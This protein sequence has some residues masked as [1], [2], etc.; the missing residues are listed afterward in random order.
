MKKVL[1]ITY[2][3]PPAGGPGVQR[4]LKFAK[5]L[6]E[7]GWQPIILTV[8]NGEY[9]A[10]DN[11]LK[12]EIPDSCIVYRTKSLEPGLIYKKF[13]G[14]K[15]NYKIPV[16]VLTEKNL[17]WK[18]RLAN[19]IRLNLII[20]D[21]KI[22]WKSFA[23]KEGKKIINKHK[24]DII[25]SSSPPPTVHLIARK[26]A[27]W[28]KLRWISDFRDPWTKIH[29][30]RGFTKNYFAQRLD[31]A[32]EKSVLDYASKI[33]AVNRGFFDYVDQKKFIQL[34][35]GFDSNELT[36][37]KKNNANLKFTIVYSGALKTRQ[38]V[39]TFFDILKNL[40]LR[41]QFEIIGNVDP[42]VRLMMEEKQ[43]PHDVVYHGF[44]SHNKVIEAIYNSDLLLLIIGKSDISHQ[45]YSTKLFEYLMVKKPILAYG[46]INGAADNLIK[47]TSAGKLFDYDDIDGP[48]KFISE[49]YQ[50]WE[51]NISYSG[52]KKKEIEKYE[53][54]E[55]TNKLVKIFEEL[56]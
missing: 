56:L 19:W 24:P 3:W 33:C 41:I 51:K 12:R 52:F 48:K 2:Y 44:Q 50:S 29:Y 26:L 9:P 8:E 53:R 42:Q 28:S 17:S 34:T 10:S 36:V 32:L 16:A 23:V 55:L 40:S 43:L 45:I 11:S 54:K 22:G 35:N 39:G 47:T 20:P 1:I 49:H 13:I 30:Y 31:L 27:K 46:P 4:I 38:Y 5:Y 21:A 37:V 18:K 7:L 14:M 15:A 25:F 6:P